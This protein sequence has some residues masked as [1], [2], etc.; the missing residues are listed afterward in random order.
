[1]E[2][3]PGEHT[4]EL[5]YRTDRQLGFFRDYDELYWN[6]TSNGWKFSIDVARA[7]ILLPPEARRRVMNMEGYTGYQG[8]KGQAYTARRDD[9]DNPAFQAENLAAGQGLTIVVTWPKG[10]ITEPTA[11]QKRAWFIADNKPE[12]LGVAGLIVVFLY[13]L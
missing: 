6:V 11:E 13:Y 9:G 4:Y 7:T 10:V 2:L 8:E 5:R 12:I 1:Y 3:P